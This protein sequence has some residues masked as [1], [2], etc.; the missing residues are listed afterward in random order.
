MLL[1]DSVNEI[2]IPLNALRKI[3]YISQKGALTVSAHV[4]TNHISCYLFINS[5]LNSAPLLGVCVCVCVDVCMKETLQK[6]KCAQKRM[7][8]ST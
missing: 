1:K 3:G 4:E 2:L 6:C 8:N 7:H 5:S